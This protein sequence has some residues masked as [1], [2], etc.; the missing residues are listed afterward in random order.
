MEKQKGSNIHHMI[1]VAPYDSSFFNKLGDHVINLVNVLNQVRVH[2][3][4]IAPLPRYYQKI[5]EYVKDTYICSLHFESKC[6]SGRKLVFEIAVPLPVVS[7]KIPDHNYIEQNS[8]VNSKS[9]EELK[10]ENAMLTEQI[11]TLFEENN[12]LKWSNYYVKRKNMELI[13]QNNQ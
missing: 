11:K 12:K 1:G 8:S 4:V 7:E 3:I 10:R 2:V 6:F 5:E 9:A 13:L